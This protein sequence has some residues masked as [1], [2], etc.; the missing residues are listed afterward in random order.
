MWCGEF[1]FGNDRKCVKL[2]ENLFSYSVGR[3]V[4]GVKMVN[5]A[6]CLR[7]RQ[8][9]QRCG[10][11]NPDTVSTAS[12]GLSVLWV[13]ILTQRHNVGRIVGVVGCNP[14][15]VTAVSAGLSASWVII[16]AQ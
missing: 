7:C 8:G 6:E 10:Y 11:G 16:L 1:R 12:V 9:C 4:I 13:V 2:Y 14:D 3:V 5:L 15:K